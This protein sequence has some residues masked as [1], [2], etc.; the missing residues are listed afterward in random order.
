LG[1]LAL[2]LSTVGVLHVL[3]VFYYAY[4]VYRDNNYSLPKRNLVRQM[5]IF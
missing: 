1:Q 5:L 2:G 4:Q 3:V